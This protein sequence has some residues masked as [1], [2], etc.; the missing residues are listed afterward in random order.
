MAKCIGVA[1]LISKSPAGGLGNASEPSADV[2]I[3]G[4]ARVCVRTNQRGEGGGEVP[5][6]ICLHTSSNH[7]TE[8]GGP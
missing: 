7:V 2:S 4:S 1:E 3:C 5:V 8:V 6:F